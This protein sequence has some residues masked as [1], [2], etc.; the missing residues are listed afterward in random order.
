MQGLKHCE[1]KKQVT[2]LR[3]YISIGLNLIFL[4]ALPSRLDILCHFWA[5]YC[6]L[7][8]TMQSLT[9]F[10]SKKQVIFLRNYVYKY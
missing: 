6:Q 10:E 7:C 5:Y 4:E 8:H 1:S 3:K 2:F 9:H